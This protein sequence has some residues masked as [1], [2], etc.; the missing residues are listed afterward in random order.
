MKTAV[1]TAVGVIPWVLAVALIWPV[2]LTIWICMRDP[3]AKPLTGAQ[4]IGY[5]FVAMT[6]Q[7]SWGF[8][9]SYAIA[10]AGSI[11]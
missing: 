9:A 2:L 6:A 8:A 1:N 7:V 5:Y 4:S 10:N 3:E 11:S